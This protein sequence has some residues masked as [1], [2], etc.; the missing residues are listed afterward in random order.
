M[1]DESRFSGTGTRTPR[2][3]LGLA[4]GM[5]IEEV[6]PQARILQDFGIDTFDLQE[7]L[8]ALEEEFGVAFPESAGTSIRTVADIE[9]VV[10]DAEPRP[11][12]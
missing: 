8:E 1:S 2:E 5:P 6:Q 3:A 11:S 12:S 7:L 4:L 9:C 10:R